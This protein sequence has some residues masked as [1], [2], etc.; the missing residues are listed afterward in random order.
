MIN[1]TV[2]GQQVDN[3]C[4]SNGKFMTLMIVHFSVQQDVVVSPEGL[5]NDSCRLPNL[6]SHIRDNHN[7]L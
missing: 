1:W 5:I 3:T 6:Y 2:V 7:K 4:S